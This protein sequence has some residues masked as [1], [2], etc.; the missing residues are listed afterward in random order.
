MCNPL[1]I[2]VVWLSA[3]IVFACN[4]GSERSVIT[5]C[6][7]RIANP[8]YCYG[9]AVQG[10][11]RSIQGP[12][13]AYRPRACFVSLFT[14]SLIASPVSSL[15]ALAVSSLPVFTLSS[16]DAVAVLSPSLALA[17][18]SH[19]WLPLPCCHSL[20]V[21]SLAVFPVSQMK[22]QDADLNQHAMLCSPC[23]MSSLSA[24]RA[25]HCVVTLAF[26]VCL[27]CVVTRCPVCTRCIRCVVTRCLGRVITH[28]VSRLHRVVTRWLRHVVTCCLTAEDTGF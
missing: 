23:R 11:A 1:E 25:L 17:S 24:F 2:L 10:P 18:Q 3:I 21:L 4:S 22:H 16:L 13:M 26:A 9:R 5:C 20:P 15:A 7:P 8:G 14:T 27:H 28:V 12:A 6:L 19:H